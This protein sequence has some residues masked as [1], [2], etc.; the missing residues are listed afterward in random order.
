MKQFQQTSGYSVVTDIN[1][2]SRKSCPEIGLYVMF[3]YTNS[4]PVNL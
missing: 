3:F 4:V 1:F 2:Q